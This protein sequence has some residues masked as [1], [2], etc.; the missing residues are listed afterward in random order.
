MKA[1]CRRLLHGR[2][3]DKG[4][5]LYLWSIRSPYPFIELWNTCA[6]RPV[7]VHIA[8]MT[9]AFQYQGL[10][11]LTTFRLLRLH[12]GQGERIECSLQH[13]DLGSE[14][15]PSYTAIS[16]TW[17]RDKARFKIHIGDTAINIRENLRNALR[18]IRDKKTGCWL[19]IDAICIKQ[20][21]TREK[22]QQ[23]RLM[24]EIYGN[25]NY[26]LVWLQSAGESADVARAFKIVHDA[27]TYDNSTHS[28][29]RY[30]R[31]NSN[32]HERIWHSIQKLD[33]LRY[34]TRKWIIQELVLARTVVL[35]MGNRKCAMTELEE[36]CRQLHRNRD[37]DRYQKLNWSS[38]DRVLASPAARLALERSETRYS[39]EPRSLHELVERYASNEC[40]EPCDHIYAL[41][42]L[43][44]QHRTQLTIDYGAPPVQRLV[45]VLHFIN[46]HEPLQPPRVME[47]VKLLVKLL[48]INREDLLRERQLAVNFSLTVSATLLGAVEMKDESDRSFKLRQTVEPLQP[49]HEYSL[50]ASQDVWFLAPTQG[51]DALPEQV[52][53]ENMTYFGIANS[54]FRGLAACSRPLQPGDKICHFPETQ[55]VFAFRVYNDLSGR[56]LGRAYLFSTTRDSGG[57]E[58][59]LRG[60]FNQDTIRRSEKLITMS[61]A[62]LLDLSSLAISVKDS[63]T[64]S[65]MNEKPTWLLDV[66]AVWRKRWRYIL[67][68][69]S[70]S[71]STCATEYR[72]CVLTRKQLSYLAS[73]LRWSWSNDSA[74]DWTSRS[75]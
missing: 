20:D 6:P 31:A 60:S 37:N 26:V 54:S 29:Y 14:T 39:R 12:A 44:G 73:Y 41:Y 1:C 66:D 55:L 67:V 15:C 35:R 53:R 11:S 25:A 32:D 27:V 52:G 64:D 17:G 34:W 69:A 63:E 9:H 45:E 24:A 71:E 16:Y 8:E 62:T 72:L 51:S 58:Q 19:W 5:A 56:I 47:F 50:D 4:L 46:M 38:W 2:F 49:M 30:L 33:R 36:F 22:D 59:W 3:L 7:N 42:S 65:A 57:L 23:V 61:L 48:R 21:S 10:E 28:V 74:G 70:S 13:F 75:I 43:V 18:S 40:Q 68:I